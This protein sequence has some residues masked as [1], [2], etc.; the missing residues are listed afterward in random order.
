M[1][2]WRRMVEG[3]GLSV[4]AAIGLASLVVD[5]MLIKWIVKIWKSM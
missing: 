4:C 3:F 2:F 1:D 5:A